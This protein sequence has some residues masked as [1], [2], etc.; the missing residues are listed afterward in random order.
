MILTGSVLRLESCKNLVVQ[1]L[2]F[3]YAKNQDLLAALL[4]MIRI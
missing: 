4:R 2:W 3:P 1:A